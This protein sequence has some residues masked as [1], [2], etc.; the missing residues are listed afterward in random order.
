MKQSLDNRAAEMDPKLHASFPAPG[1]AEGEQVESVVEEVTR[2]G[3]KISL[4][5]GTGR[6]VLLRE[7]LTL[8][9]TGGAIDD[10]LTVRAT[11]VQ[12]R[13]RG[14][15]EIVLLDLEPDEARLVDRALNHQ[16]CIRIPV[17]GSR[18]V[19]V[20]L[21]DLAGQVDLE[22]ALVDISESGLG[23]VLTEKDDRRLA[24]AMVTA[25]TD[26]S[27]SL[28]I[29]FEL[30]AT[31]APMVLIGQVRYRMLVQNFVKYGIAFDFER[32]Q[33]AFPGQRQTV[34]AHMMAYQQ[35]LLRA[36]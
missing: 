28:E 13:R 32:S 24:E 4:E 10:H 17:R 18:A 20:R 22:A 16:R 33:E 27:W 5:P 6:G 12:W 35:G 31:E 14:D 25:D 3:M 1:G 30:P 19:R 21:E 34:G 11:P 8:E 7:P 26:E 2:D 15:R 23:V 36:G 9:M 29:G